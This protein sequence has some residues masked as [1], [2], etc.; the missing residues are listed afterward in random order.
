MSTSV[1]VLIPA[2]MRDLAITLVTMMLFSGLRRTP[3]KRNLVVALTAKFFLLTGPHEVH[4]NVRIGSCSIKNN[5]EGIPPGKTTSRSVLCLGGGI[6]QRSFLVYLQQ[7]LH[8]FCLHWLLIFPDWE[9]SH[10]TLMKK[11]VIGKF[12]CK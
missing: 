2:G 7:K 12:G 8:Q 1:L 4:S 3:T 6:I 10:R 9:A 11:H 5:L